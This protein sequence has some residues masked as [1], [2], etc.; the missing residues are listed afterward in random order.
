MSWHALCFTVALRHPSFREV[1]RVMAAHDVPREALRG[2]CFMARGLLR[3]SSET[4][5]QEYFFSRTQFAIAIAPGARVTVPETMGQRQKEWARRA[6]MDLLVVLGGQCVCCGT[7]QDL[8]FDCIAPAGDRHHRL[9]TSAR[10]SFYRSQHYHH[11]N[12]QILCRTC[13]SKKGG[14]DAKRAARRAAL[15]SKGN[16]LVFSPLS[17]L[18]YSY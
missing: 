4:N 10:M 17:E 11:A 2:F 14:I 9:D 7:T 1:R 15:P 18:E 12:L 5:R 16:T 3:S 6:R 8:E 13:N